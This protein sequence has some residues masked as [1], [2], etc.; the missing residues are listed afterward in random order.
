MHMRRWHRLD[1]MGF[2]SHDASRSIN[3]GVAGDGSMGA[4]QPDGPHKEVAFHV[5]GRSWMRVRSYAGAANTVAALTG[6]MG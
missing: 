3:G 2:I 6:M 4:G 5:I 1:L